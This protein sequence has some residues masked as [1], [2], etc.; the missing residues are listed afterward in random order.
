MVEAI[1]INVD[2]TAKYLL[3]QFDDDNNADDITTGDQLVDVLDD[4]TQINILAAVGDD[5]IVGND[6]DDLI[7]GDTPFTDALA[8][9]EGIGQAPGSGWSVIEALIADDF[10][11][12]D[13]GRSVN[14]EKIG[15]AHGCTPVTN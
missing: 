2:D 14:E 11:D 10:F 7:F 15:R 6:G 1:G 12:Q 13:A 3:D 8:A 5:E 9:D 4:L